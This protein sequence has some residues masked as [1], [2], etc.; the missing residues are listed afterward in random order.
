MDSR[1][2][3]VIF[4]RHLF[5]MTCNIQA[6][7]DTAH[8][9]GFS[10][11]GTK[12]PASLSADLADALAKFFRREFL[13]RVDR[14]ISFQTLT[15]AGFETLFRRRFALLTTENQPEITLGVSDESVQQFCHLCVAQGEGVRGFN[16]LFER[17]IQNVVTQEISALPEQ[18]AAEVVWK[19]GQFQVEVNSGGF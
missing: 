17:M 11:V 6:D 9:I 3:K 8:R 7:G 14:I 2:R 19:D 15:A 5:V 1:G 16:R 4:A 10:S 18:S 12:R 13:A